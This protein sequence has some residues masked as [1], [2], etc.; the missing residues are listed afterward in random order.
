MD[1]SIRQVVAI[2]PLPM[3]LVGPDGRIRAVNAELERLFEYPPGALEGELVEMLLPE[4]VA[5][6]HPELRAAYARVP[7]KRRM[8]RGRDLHGRTRTGRVLPLELGLHPFEEGGETHV[9]VTAVDITERKRDEERVRTAIDAAASSMILVSPTG[10][11][12]L[13]NPAA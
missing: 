11:I 12:E 2:G 10:T 8:G 3:L 5:S 13:V 4:A 7:T 1:A 9:L 6:R